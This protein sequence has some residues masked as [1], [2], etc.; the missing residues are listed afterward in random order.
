MANNYFVS[1]TGKKSTFFEDANGNIDLPAVS[2]AFDTATHYSV[3][4]V[5]E[6][7]GVLYKA[8]STIAAGTDFAT[9]YEAGDWVAVTGVDSL[10][11]ADDS[12]VYFYEKDLRMLVLDSENHVRTATLKGQTV[13]AYDSDISYLTGEIVDFENSLW[14]ATKLALRHPY[15]DSLLD[16]EWVQ[17]AGAGGGGIEAYDSDKGWAQNDLRVYGDAIYAAN[18]NKVGSGAPF[19]VASTGDNTWRPIGQGGVIGEYGE[20]KTSVTN[21]TNVGIG[22][23]IFSFPINSE[24]AFEIDYNVI[25]QQGGYEY[26]TFAVY[27]SAGTIID[28]TRRTAGGMSVAFDQ[29]FSASCQIE[30]AGGKTGTYT[31]RIADINMGGVVNIRSLDSGVLPGWSALSWSKVSGY[32]P[33]IGYES[34]ILNITNTL[35]PTAGSGTAD[36]DYAAAGTSARLLFS[37]AD[38]IVNTGYTIGTNTITINT[39]G[40]YKFIADYSATDNGVDNT[41]LAM[42][43]GVN[44]VAYG[45]YKSSVAPGGLQLQVTV[46]EIAEL[47]VGDVVDFRMFNGTTSEVVKQSPRTTI[48]VEKISKNLAI[49]N[50]DFVRK[51]DGIIG[52]TSQ[53]IVKSPDGALGFRTKAGTS[54][55]LE[56][57]SYVGGNWLF[58][59]VY[60]TGPVG[61]SGLGVGVSMD[62]WTDLSTGTWD[63]E[64]FMNITHLYNQDTGKMYRATKMIT[65]G[66][67]EDPIVIEILS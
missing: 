20:V 40:T 31:L 30:V 58:Y 56:G 7:D 6:K 5:V 52:I 45:N 36:L 64:G 34:K 50:N 8:T 65:N 2:L 67:T 66:N 60:M 9:A 46:F 57:I 49:T 33:A 4:S 24:G 19:T 42:Q 3:D 1:R 59:S 26:C 25:L 11:A 29:G 43:M 39:A 37:G 10:G 53:N 41:T 27:D 62:S 18:T 23:T 63:T 32:I 47:N 55:A 54:G 51:D 21:G 16:S 14:K 22:G 48:L 13:Q 44:G 61:R 12:E 38:A 35:E 17:V 28:S 15:G